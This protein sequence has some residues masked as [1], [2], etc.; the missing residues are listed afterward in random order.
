MKAT[1]RG[2]LACSLNVK[3]LNSL[4]ADRLVIK[5]DLVGISYPIYSLYNTGLR[6]SDSRNAQTY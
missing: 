6:L 4:S 1:V 2:R 3:A 5:L